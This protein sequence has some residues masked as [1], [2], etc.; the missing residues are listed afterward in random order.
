MKVLANNLENF[1]VVIKVRGLSPEEVIGKPVQADFPLYKGR[2]VMIQAEFRGA[3]RQAYT[4]EPCY[5]EGT[6]KDIQQLKLHTNKERAIFIAVA[7]TTYR[8]LRLVSN[9]VHCRDEGPE[10]CGA[11]IAEYLASNI[12]PQAK[13]LMI[14]FQPAI[15]YHLSR[16]FKSY[17]VTDI[18]PAN[19]G[20]V[21]RGVLIESYEKNK[22]AINWSDVVLVTG[23][24]IVNNS[25]D[26][27][28][29]LCSRKK[30]ILKGFASH[31]ISV[32]T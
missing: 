8:F 5:Y 21:K 6:L 32:F 2:E 3:L 31:L 29:R 15:A 7:N 16:M 24:T 30:V 17:R 11:K 13:V 10:I 9:T 1:E 12:S 20:Q 22:E 23:S 26:E 27:I 18:D 14:G 19:V 4:D 25:I 28:I